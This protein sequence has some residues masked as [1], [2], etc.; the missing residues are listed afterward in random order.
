M[1]SAE[2]LKTRGLAAGYD[3]S[4][5]KKRTLI[6]GHFLVYTDFYFFS[7]R[8]KTAIAQDCQDC[9]I[10]TLLWTFEF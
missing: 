5:Q 9:N 4:G 2:K 1:R 8:Q 10:F 7:A 3:T 6:V